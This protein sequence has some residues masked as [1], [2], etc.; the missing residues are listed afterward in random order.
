MIGLWEE[1]EEHTV[2]TLPVAS[3]GESE[4]PAI[5]YVAWF[6]LLVFAVVFFWAMLR[7]CLNGHGRAPMYQGY[8]SSFDF[9]S[10]PRFLYSLH[11]ADNLSFVW[12]GVGRL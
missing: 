6:V 9:Y 7:C 8:E 10:C 12:E 1:I 2:R 4:V 5:S 3:M 11:P